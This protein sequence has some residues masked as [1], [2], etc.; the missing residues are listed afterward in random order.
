MKLNVYENIEWNFPLR[1]CFIQ[2]S[3]HS[4]W[5]DSLGNNVM[6]QTDLMQNNV[7]KQ[8]DLMQNNVMKQTDLM[9]WYCYIG[10]VGQPKLLINF[11]LLWG[12]GWRAIPWRGVPY[13]IYLEL[14]TVIQRRNNCSITQK[15]VASIFPSLHK[16][17]E[18]SIITYRLEELYI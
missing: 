1:I 16:C 5:H 15:I 9:H 2:V 14:C 3:F 13:L 17:W 10:M 6:K 4:I 7:M 18:I 12:L 8:T 11:F